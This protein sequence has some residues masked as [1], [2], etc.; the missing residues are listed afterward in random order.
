MVDFELER[1]HGRVKVDAV[2]EAHEEELRVALAA[3]AGPR[4]LADLADL[5]EDEVRDD[6]ALRLEEARVD[7]PRQLRLRITGRTLPMLC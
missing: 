2:E 7:L 3:I 6:V 1:A 4:A 5:D